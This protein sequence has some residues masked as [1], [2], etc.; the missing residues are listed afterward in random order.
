MVYFRSSRLTFDLTRQVQLCLSARRITGEGTRLRL[1]EKHKGVNQNI[2]Y[3]KL[4]FYIF[5]I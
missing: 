2:V 3:C 5:T 1:D 4:E